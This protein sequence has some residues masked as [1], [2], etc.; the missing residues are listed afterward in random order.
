MIKLYFFVE[1]IITGNAYLDMLELY[2]FPYGQQI[3]MEK[4]LWQEVTA[5]PHLHLALSERIPD[6]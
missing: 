2:T 5:L 3:E 4:K 1:L 6:Q